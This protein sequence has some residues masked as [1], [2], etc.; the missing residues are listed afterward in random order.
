MR[1]VVVVILR[2]ERQE[3]I[4]MPVDASRNQDRV[5]GRTQ[6]SSLVVDQSAL[7]LLLLTH[8]HTYIVTAKLHF[9]QL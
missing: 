6:G 1:L 9:S 5:R 2:R 7:A 4:S 3:E 8:T